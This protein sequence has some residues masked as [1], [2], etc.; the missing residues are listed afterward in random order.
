[1]RE[2]DYSSCSMSYKAE[3]NSNTKGWLCFPLNLLSMFLYLCFLIFIFL[4]D[5]TESILSLYLW[6]MLV[7]PLIRLFCRCLLSFHFDHFYLFVHCLSP[8]HLHFF[9]VF[10]E[11]LLDVLLFIELRDNLL[12]WFIVPNLDEIR[13]CVRAK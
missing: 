6:R 9:L 8:L 5:I 13:W 1:M 2:H 10:V 7:D 3:M 11:H 12:C 4:I